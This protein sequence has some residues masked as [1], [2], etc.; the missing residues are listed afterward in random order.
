MTYLDFDM[1]SLSEA[2]QGAHPPIYAD[3][4]DSR[5]SA[6]SRISR[7]TDDRSRRAS[8]EAPAVPGRCPDLRRSNF[9]LPR[10]RM[11]A[12]HGVDP[13]WALVWDLLVSAPNFGELLPRLRQTLEGIP[14]G[15][16]TE[17][18]DFLPG[19]RDR[20]LIEVVDPS[21]R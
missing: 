14:A 13:V 9:S 5:Y 7:V 11:S 17:I 20:E 3:P 4:R 16:E 1:R 8:L 12:Y 15:F 19:L 21:R 10:E 6:Q 18:A 2:A